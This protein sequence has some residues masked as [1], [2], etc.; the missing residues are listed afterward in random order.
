MTQ[1]LKLSK[2]IT[3]Q[4]PNLSR[5]HGDSLALCWVNLAGHDAATR[6]VL[7]QRQLSQTTPGARS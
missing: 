5:D 1:N 2:T 3:I 7:R 4:F 6:L